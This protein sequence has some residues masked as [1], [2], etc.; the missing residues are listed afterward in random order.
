MRVLHDEFLPK[1]LKREVQ[2]NRPASACAALDWSCIME[3]HFIVD[4]IL[5][6]TKLIYV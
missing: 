1:K 4:D 3:T 6:G 5:Q 2:A